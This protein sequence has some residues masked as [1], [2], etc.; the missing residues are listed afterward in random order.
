MRERDDDADLHADQPRTR[1][2]ALTGVGFT[3]P[4]PAG[5]VVATPNGLTGTC[6]GTVTA[7][8]GAGSVALVN[9]ALAAGGSCTITLNVTGVDGRR[10]EQRHECR[11]LDR[12]R[13]GR[14]PPR[15]PR[16][17]HQ[18]GP[19]ADPFALGARDSGFARGRRR[20]VSLLP[21]PLR[22]RR[23]ARLAPPGMGRQRN[24][25]AGGAYLL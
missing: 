12:G 21:P 24:F 19:G 11:H 5:L 3:D 22:G 16:G 15:Q 14:R 9:G 4:L 13:H 10:Q 20:R 2:T 6:G 18:G 25:P 1:R 23:C 8:A 17:G 7:V